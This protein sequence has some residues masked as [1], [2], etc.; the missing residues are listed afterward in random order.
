MGGDQRRTRVERVGERGDGA[1]ADAAPTSAA[2]PPRRSPMRL[3]R[4]ISSFVSRVL[5]PPKPSAMSDRPS[6]CRQPVTSMVVA[7]AS[8][9]AT[10]DRH[11]KHQRRDIDQAARQPD[12]DA[13]ERGSPDRLRQRA[14]AKIE[15]GQ[16]QPREEDE[17]EHDIVGDLAR[18]SWLSPRDGVEERAADMAAPAAGG[19]ER[20]ALS[21]GDVGERLVGAGVDQS[22]R[23]GTRG[24]ARRCPP[25]RARESA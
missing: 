12:R 2:P 13:G 19:S 24:R 15:G 9:A 16:R 22:A 21:V 6:S 11:R 23:S 3:S 4:M 8:A 25:G 7:S 17:A 5:P 10:G 1:P 20:V 14:A 18:L